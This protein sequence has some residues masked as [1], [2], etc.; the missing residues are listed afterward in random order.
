MV[1]VHHSFFL[2]C[3]DA[4][5]LVFWN[6]FT[7]VIRVISWSPDCHTASEVTLAVMGTIDPYP[8]HDRSR[9]V[10]I[11]PVI[12][13]MRYSVYRGHM[14]VVIYYIRWCYVNEVGNGRTL[15]IF[16]LKMKPVQNTSTWFTFLMRLR[17]HCFYDTS[18]QNQNCGDTVWHSFV[19]LWDVI[20]HF[21]LHETIGKPIV[22]IWSDNL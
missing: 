14:A 3:F 6:P 5:I 16:T 21:I 8:N 9:T 11:T 4:I 18:A 13:C 7:H 19:G 1:A 22:K 10:C 20:R 17:F 2:Y 15:L 12:Y